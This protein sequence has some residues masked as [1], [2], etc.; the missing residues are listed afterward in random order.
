MRNRFLILVLGT[1]ITVA[2]C[3]GGGGQG[4]TFSSGVDPG[5]RGDEMTQDEA[6]QMCEAWAD[7]IETRINSLDSCRFVGV[8]VATQYAGD[9]QVTEADL[10]EICAEA[11]DDCRDEGL[12]EPLIEASDLEWNERAPPSD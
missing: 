10:R 4:T 9:S 1:L 8:F 11:E 7:Y 6:M 5:K 2:A 12:E 3:G